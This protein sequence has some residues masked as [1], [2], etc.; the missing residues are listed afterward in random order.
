MFGNRPIARPASMLDSFL[1]PDTTTDKVR[2]LFWLWVNAGVIGNTMFASVN[3]FSEDA[4]ADWIAS[5]PLEARAAFIIGMPT[6]L[7]G[8]KAAAQKLVTFCSSGETSANNGQP[9]TRILAHSAAAAIALSHSV[10]LTCGEEL[11]LP[12]TVIE[13]AEDL[14]PAMT[15]LT[16][17]AGAIVE[18]AYQRIGQGAQ[19][20]YHW[21]TQ[22]AA[23]EE[24]LQPFAN[25]GSRI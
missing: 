19:A 17:V 24:S 7:A 15:I 4:I 25:D 8:V 9:S 11:G 12:R 13:T 6:L 18:K 1:N 2:F 23:T 20:F 10:A 3:A 22:P 14:S 5:L 21:L 16:P